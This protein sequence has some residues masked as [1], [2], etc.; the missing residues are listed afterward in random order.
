V[1]PPPDGEWGIAEVLAH[2]V[3]S[4]LV[5]GVRVR[6]IVAAEHPAIPAYDQDAWAERFAD[7]DGGDPSSW[8]AVWSALRDRNLRVLAGLSAAEWG[9]VGRH[10][11]RGDESVADV[12]THLA[13]HDGEHLEQLRGLLATGLAS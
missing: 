12:V 6:T 13:E 1:A 2:L 10:A 4:E 8:L 3:H 7:S 11:E 9:H 5:Y